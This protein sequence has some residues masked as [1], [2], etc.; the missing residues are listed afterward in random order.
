MNFTFNSHQVATAKKFGLSTVLPTM[1]ELVPLSWVADYFIGIGD[2]LENLFAWQGLDFHSVRVS[3]HVLTNG[4]YAVE[5]KN[6]TTDVVRFW[7]DSQGRVQS[8]RTLTGYAYRFKDFA[9]QREILLG[10]PMQK[11][12]LVNPDF[13]GDRGLSKALNLLALFGQFQS[14]R[15]RAR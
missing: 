12:P 8:Y 7:W 4:S 5:P 15:A 11:A 14:S 3:R 2:Y 1:W 9:F 10:F 6:P 13:S